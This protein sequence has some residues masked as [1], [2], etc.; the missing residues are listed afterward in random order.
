MIQMI[1]SHPLSPPN[2]NPS[3][4][5]LQQQSKIRRRRH[6]FPPHPELQEFPQ[7]VAAKSLMLN[8]PRFDYSLYY[9]KSHKM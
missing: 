2:P 1:L 7:P 6:P 3:P 8:P 5:P 4:Q 9:S